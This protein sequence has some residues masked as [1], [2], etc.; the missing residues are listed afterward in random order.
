LF[1]FLSYHFLFMPPTA[2][3]CAR[4]KQKPHKN[5]GC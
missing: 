1:I 3:K 4:A 2:F 5:V